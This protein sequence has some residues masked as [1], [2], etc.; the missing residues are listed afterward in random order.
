M[1]TFD[2]WSALG[3]RIKKGSTG[4]REDGKVFFNESQVWKWEPNPLAFED[5]VE[6]GWV[7]GE[8]QGSY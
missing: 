6:E 5:E 8:G 2:E 7:W 1:K 4:H 3:Y